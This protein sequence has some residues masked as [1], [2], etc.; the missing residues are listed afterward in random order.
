MYN[1]PTFNLKCDIYTGPWLTKVLR[2]S[3]VDCN[4]ALGR[5]VQQ[6]GNDYANL[7]YGP[8]APNLL[9]PL[10]TDVRDGANA[11]GQDIVECPAGTGRWYQVTAVDD[12]GKGFSNEYR[13]AALCKISAFLDPTKYSGLFW[14]T[15]IP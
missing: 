12:V 7:S 15:P 2:A 6:Q 5:R 14:P 13:L 4:L 9:L 3:N 1:P 10:G 11:S 8:A